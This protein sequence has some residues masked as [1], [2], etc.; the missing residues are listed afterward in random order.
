[1]K[2]VHLLLAAICILILN[3]A[4]GQKAA[5]PAAR[6]TF[7]KVYLHT[8]RECFWAGENIWFKAYLINGQLNQL[9]ASSNSLTIE[10][11]NSSSQ[12]V[13]KELIYLK[14]GVG[15][16]DFKLDSSYVE[17]AYRIKAYTTL[18]TYFG[19]NLLF[20]KPI[21]IYN[22]SKPGSSVAASASNGVGS[23]PKVVSD[24]KSGTITFY[25]ESGSLVENVSS[26]VAFKSH[27]ENQ[28]AI[29]LSGKVVSSTGEVINSFTSDSTGMGSFTIK[30]LANSKYFAKGK[31]Q[32]GQSFEVELPTALIK[33]FSLH[34]DN[35]DSELRITVNANDLA[36][37]E[38]QN[39]E[40]T[41]VC[42]SKGRSY[43]SRKIVWSQNQ[44]IITIPKSSLAAGITEVCLYDAAFKPY[45]ERLV[46]NDNDQRLNILVTTD[47]PIYGPKEKVKLSIKVTDK[48]NKPVDAN[49]SIAVI[50][51]DLVPENKI[52]IVS[53]L[54]IKSEIRGNI[55][56]VKQYFDKANPDRY[57]QLD[58]LLLTQGWRDFTWRRL[59]DSAMRVAIKPRPEMLSNFAQIKEKGKP[60]SVVPNKII[61]KDTIALGQVVIKGQQSVKLLDQT[62]KSYGKDDVLTVEP[63]DYDHKNLR[64]YL[65][66]YAAGA[67]TD[68]DDNIYFVGSGGK[69]LFPRLVI[70]NVSL[71]FTDEEIDKP[72]RDQYYQQYLNM[73]VSEFEK[74]VIKRG[75]DRSRDRMTRPDN[76]GRIPINDLYVMFITLNSAISRNQINALKA[77]EKSF[78]ESREFYSPDYDNI[79]VNKDVRTTIHW[80]PNKITDENGVL[81]LS[82]FNSTASGKIMVFV[83]GIS[84]TSGALSAK[85]E[86]SVK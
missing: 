13:S 72:M 43:I 31:F 61:S 12:V 51:A 21:Y 1:M 75:V 22:N 63:K 3:I 7:E 40:F 2:N 10:L 37:Q 9:S 29:P 84:E 48:Q 76:F 33:G 74:I 38:N 81:N 68:V 47:K 69:Q 30:P 57:K 39:S 83:E 42:K 50:D 32:N 82:F 54:E 86:Y 35:L 55:Q 19:D 78:Y 79:N 18:M 77:Y 28:K 62:F 49:L 52:D 24:N 58:L 41:L 60:E 5:K 34:T 71:P 45:C 26:V 6:I 56:N 67:L 17:G 53:Y 64:H 20:E 36:L 73:P 59:V 14:N 15:K 44:V 85:G 4:Y 11:I 27:S 70:N 65:I 25:P 8:D 16:G 23:L 46:Y 66:H 80:E